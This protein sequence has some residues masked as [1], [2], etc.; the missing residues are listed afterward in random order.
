MK[1][2]ILQVMTAVLLIMT[3]TM[4]NVLLLCADVVSYAANE[5]NA[6]KS[7]NHKNV[8]FM[9][10]FK[11]KEGNKTTSLDTY[12]DNNDLKLYFQVSVKKEGYFNGNIVLNNANF[13]FKTDSLSDGISKIENNVIYL[14]Q[15][16]A[17][18][19]KELEV[20]IELIKDEQFDLNLINMESEISIEGVYRDSTQKDISIKS[21]KNVNLK[22][23][24]SYT[25]AEDSIELSQKVITNKILKFNGEDK[26][27][28]Q[29]KIN[30]G[31]KDN[32]FPISN[33]IINIQTP[34]ISDKYPEKVFVNSNDVLATNGKML[35][36]ENW[37]YNEETGVIDVNVE[38]QKENNKVSW[39]KNG[40]D[41]IIVTYVFD[42][43]VELNN[44]KSEIKSKIQ[45]YD[46]KTTVMNAS[47]GMTLT[48]DE[49][50]SIVTTSFEQNEEN[51]YKGKL[52]A[53]ISRDITYKNIIDVN[54]NNIASEINVKEDKQ[55]IEGQIINS[56]YK[57]SK[58]S[59]ADIENILGDNGS[60]D[61]INSENGSV[62][63][64]IN[65]NTKADE[66]GYIVISYPENVTTISIKINGNE[67]IGR[68]NIETT[69]TINSI[70][71]TLV[72][73]AGSIEQKSFVSYF[74][75]DKESKLDGAESNIKLNET[76]TSV[77][78][79]I[80]RTELSTM[81]TNNNVEFRITLNS[82]NEKNEL[83]K[84]PVLKLELPEKIQDIQVNSIKLLYEDEMKVKTATLKNK[85]IEIA[86][87]GEQT[88]YKEEAIDGAMII[89]NANLKTTPKIPNSTEQVKLTYTNQSVIN[90]ENNAKEGSTQKDINIV[91]YAGVV[92]TSQILDYGIDVVNNEGT[93]SAKLDVST[94]SKNTN[95]EK[96]VINNK[97]NK[98]SNVKI[99][100]VFPTKGAIASNNIDIQVGNI[101]VSGIDSTRVKVYYS[102]NVEA[103]EDLDNKNNGWTEQISNV[104]NVKKYL[105][106]LDEL[107]VLEEMDISYP[108][109][110][111]AN[112]EY[113]K[114]AEEGYNVYYQD[115]VTAVSEK[116]NLD[117]IKL[118]TGKGPVIDTSLKA[119]VGS[120]ETSE[121]KEGEIISYV[122]TVS[123]T[124]T[125]DITDIKLTG[126]V[127]EN[128]VYVEKNKLSN[129]MSDEAA[130]YVPFTEYKDKQNVEINID[131]LAV[132]ETVTK[133]YQV[134][135]KSGAE[136]KTVTNSVITKYGDVTKTSN[137]VT[138]N[139]KKGEIQ[140]D[141]YPVD[142][143]GTLESGYFY[144]YVLA[145]TNKSD[146]E[147]K[148][149][150]VNANVNDVVEL[151]EI[152][153]IN[154]NGE[155]ISEKENNFINVDS[156]E[157]GETVDVAIFVKAKT[158][159]DKEMLNGV[160]SANVVDKDITYNSNTED[161][162]I[163]GVNIEA[164]ITSN[165]SDSYVKA[166]D[167]IEYSIIVKNNGNINVDNILVKDTI[168]DKTALV[169][170]TKNGEKLSEDKYSKE[171]EI[172]TGNKIIKISDKLNI[173][174][175]IEYKIKV[176]V[177]KVPGNTKSIEIINNTNITVNN[178]IEIVN[179]D[180][181]H[182]LEPEKTE[183]VN[184]DDPDNPINPDDDKNNTKSIS[185]AVWIDENQNGGKDSGEQLLSGITVKLLDVK[186]NT[187]VKD[188]NGNELSVTTNENGF[189]SFDKLKAGEYIVIFEYDTSKYILAAYQ[190]DGIDS[191][192]NSKVISKTLS[193]DG[194][195]T[196]VG[197]TEVIKLDKENIANI[198]MGLQ[199]AK[200]FDLKL[201]KYVSK[202]VIQ[203]AK[204]TTT[205]DYGNSTFAK[206]EIDAK[207][208]NNTTAVVEYTIKVTNAGEVDAYVKKIAD[209]IPKDYKFTSELNKDWYQSG[210]TLYNSSL[211]NEKIKPGESKEVKLI[212]TKQM[213]ENNTGL[214]HNTAEVVESYNDLGLKDE[215]KNNS[216]SADLILSIKTGQVVTTITLI[217]STIVIIGAATYII[218]KFVLTKKV[219]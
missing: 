121:V 215:N 137:E 169:E 27:I 155:A 182:I 40:D 96:K 159:T 13:K 184:P 185:G 214:I 176:L 37:T 49:K 12:T 76:E 19:S 217:L 196:T 104:Q 180:I 67:K 151:Q 170:V 189:Y 138:A 183:P 103:T 133:T 98:I 135:V 175:Q 100:G 69:K 119:Y 109:T 92:T 91:S 36:E 26:R 114:V 88:K 131:K 43:D 35:S 14:N 156:I 41:S 28:I 97:E 99:L 32:L 219:I 149:L 42:K 10:Y 84:N 126:K 34:K 39:V 57:T 200:N 7:T 139:A 23:V 127:P 150:K 50:D 18:E 179:K 213:T 198:N 90:Y 122:M 68:L 190:K 56:V 15:I 64:T 197:S 124:G 173:G 116:T 201:D 134:R 45:L 171:N 30:S 118:E 210:D 101:V 63:A 5:I 24:S 113:N 59:E 54:L 75:G 58:I 105:V 152:Y 129:D 31:I 25:V 93:K 188:S 172:K 106:V 44:E 82:K 202:V 208:L 71:K 38:N 102:D 158:S 17:G 66:N 160:I 1:Q 142:S 108:M 33:S 4:A 117:N 157:P 8:E 192:N 194:K 53:G 3:L 143:D 48:K 46:T 161:V 216:N 110:I 70:D 111:P 2:R 178:S 130:E 199:I 77:S 74:S 9:G 125:E 141:L 162:T 154:K 78:L 52:Y 115:G 94:D 79:E 212:V 174:E 203:N 191:N 163:K 206:A 181:K 62:I 73:K 132:G 207:Q 47:S 112:L 85:T 120:E 195:E 177:N 6:D 165:N 86:L 148:N 123:N 61:I 128:T 204:G 20:G 95:I 11:D 16:N 145:I 81:T 29:I 87:E 209:Y 89:I 55:T 218:G 168:S 51:I 153:Y 65:K 144:R 167:T 72:K 205:K 107:N 60:L 211:S 186:T 83:F 147:K 164:K 80:N 22:L 146:K 193:I 21:K 187:F 140:A 166:G 136:G